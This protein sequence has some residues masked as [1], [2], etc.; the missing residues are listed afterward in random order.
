VASFELQG[1]DENGD[2]WACSPEGRGVWC[3]NLG[4]WEEAAAVMSQWL[5]S[6]DF[7]EIEAKR[8]VSPSRS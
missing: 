8:D 1:P 3:R 6:L 4:P 7:D 5:G 2:A